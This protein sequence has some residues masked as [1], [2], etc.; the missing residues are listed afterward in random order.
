MIVDQQNPERP[1]RSRAPA[2]PRSAGA[3]VTRLSLAMAD[4]STRRRASGRDQAKPCSCPGGAVDV[5][6]AAEQCEPFLD[7]EQT[8]SRP[9][10][11]LSFDESSRVEADPAVRHGDAE[12]VIL[13]E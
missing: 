5:E 2:A 4:R 1:R 13:I 11:L 9:A 6:P 12:R 10:G 7:A 8:P 3:V